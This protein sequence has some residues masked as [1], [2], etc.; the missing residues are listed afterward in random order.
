MFSQNNITTDKHWSYMATD[1]DVYV[2]TD[3][4]FFFRKEKYL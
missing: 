1:F 2:C 4:R 3:S